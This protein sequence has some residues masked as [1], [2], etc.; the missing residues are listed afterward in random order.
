M[1]DFRTSL[2]FNDRRRVYCCTLF[3]LLKSFYAG[4]AHEWLHKYVLYVGIY[5]YPK[6]KVFL[7]KI[8]NNRGGKI[9]EHRFMHAPWVNMKRASSNWPLQNFRDEIKGLGV[10]GRPSENWG[11]KIF[12]RY[13]SH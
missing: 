11:K 6:R 2:A 8:S 9:V 10:D 12:F 7:E 5:V 4:F 1:H 13:V 3:G